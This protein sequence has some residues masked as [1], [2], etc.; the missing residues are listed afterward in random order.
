MKIITEDHDDEISAVNHS[1]DFNIMIII[2]F[3]TFGPHNFMLQT[4]KNS[5]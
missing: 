5:F 4:K 3:H 2:L 1:T